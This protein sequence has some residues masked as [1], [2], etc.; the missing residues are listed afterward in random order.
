[1]LPGLQRVRR[2]LAIA[3]DTSA[4]DSDVPL[5]DA[6]ASRQQSGFVLWTRIWGNRLA[7]PNSSETVRTTDWPAESERRTGFVIPV[8]DNRLDPPI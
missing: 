6:V 4:T 7:L 8:P 2:D 5:P 3:R 1:V